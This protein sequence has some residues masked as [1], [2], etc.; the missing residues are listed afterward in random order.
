MEAG[1]RPGSYRGR[2][3]RRGVM[4]SRVIDRQ[5]PEYCRWY[6]M[7]LSCLGCCSL[8]QVWVT[9]EMESCTGG[10]WL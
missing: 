10:W 2:G 7:L 5:R 3:V 8:V 4:G 9:S 1:Q 6:L